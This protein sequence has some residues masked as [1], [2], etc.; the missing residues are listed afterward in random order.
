MINFLNAAIVAT[1]LGDAAVYVS[2]PGIDIT[3]NTHV[4]VGLKLLFLVI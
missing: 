3:T 4:K 1:T 2:S